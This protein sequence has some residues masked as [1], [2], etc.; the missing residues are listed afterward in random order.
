MVQGRGQCI[1]GLLV[2]SQAVEVGQSA[3]GLASGATRVELGNGV[4][5]FLIGKNQ[6]QNHLISSHPIKNLAHER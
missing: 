2:N 3:G 4:V 5:V 6:N 1:F